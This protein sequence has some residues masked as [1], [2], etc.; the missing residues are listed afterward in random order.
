MS[1]ERSHGE[2]LAKFDDLYE[3][4]YP[5]LAGQ[6]DPG[7]GG[8]Y[9]ARSSREDPE[10]Q[11]D[12][13]STSQALSIIQRSGLLEK[14]PDGMRR[15]LIAFYHQRQAPE[16]YFYDPH[17]NMRA[18]DRMV[19]RALNF[20]ARY[21]EA[22]GDRPRY[23]LPGSAGIASL[24]EYMRSPAVFRQWMDE[25]PWD[26]AWM[27]CDNIGAAGFYLRYLPEA[28]RNLLLDLIWDYIESRQNP[29]TGMWGGGRPYVQLSGAFKFTALYEEYGRAMPRPQQL[30]QTVLRTIREDVSE[31][32]CW[33]R[34]TVD[35][36]ATLEPQIGP[37]P[38]ADL[39]EILAI[40]YRN[41]CQYLKPD[42]GFSRHVGHSLAIPNN[43]PLGKGLAEGDMNAATQALRIRSLCHRI[44]GQP[45]PPLS[46]YTQGFY[47]RMA[48]K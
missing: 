17:N 13:E 2:M 40:T 45:E 28:E 22:L 25:R 31:D 33:T 46:K 21:L 32:M 35:L 42:G 38:E 44:A 36:L 20:S 18:V 23:P 12:I 24:P 5:W 11:P 15:R 37:Y 29:E 9:Y 34:N 4:F 10:F 8:F 39:R 7:Y 26:Y 19:A 14:M 48:Q 43:V 1:G 41:L 30:Y 3:G 16:G 27:A 47:E 6:Y